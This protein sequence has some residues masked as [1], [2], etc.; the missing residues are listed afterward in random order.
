MTTHGNP[1]DAA[2]GERAR[3]VVPGGMWGHLHA[4]KLPEGYPQFFPVLK[5]AGS[6][7]STGA[8]ISTSC[9]AGGQTCSGTITRR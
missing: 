5:D 9:A 7:T 1:L 4:G 3:R 2:L 6:G 8:P